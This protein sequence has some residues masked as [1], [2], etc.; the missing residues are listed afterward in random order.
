[1]QQH[2]EKTNMPLTPQDFVSKW[3]RVTAGEKQRYQERFIDLCNLVG[4][5]AVRV[6]MQVSEPQYGSLKVAFS[7]P[8]HQQV[9]F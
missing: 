3:K 2:N 5:F 1:M 9:P 7:R 8:A 6:F 4:R